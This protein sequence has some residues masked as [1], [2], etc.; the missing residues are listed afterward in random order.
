M[1]ALKHLQLL[2][3]VL[4]YDL[5]GVFDLRQRI[6]H[7]TAEKIAFANPWFL[8]KP[9]NEVC[10]KK[11]MQASLVLHFAGGWEYLCR[12]KAVEQARDESDADKD[13][14][15]F[16]VRWLQKGKP[17]TIQCYY[18]EFGG[19]QYGRREKMF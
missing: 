13:H 6:T 7:A 9:D 8:F 2:I 10:S 3:E 5:R 4:D 16:V 12:R 17:S 14:T 15:Q 19:K 1:E 18:F 11:A